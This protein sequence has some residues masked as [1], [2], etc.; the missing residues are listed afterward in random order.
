MKKLTSNTITPNKAFL[1][2]LAFF[3][4]GVFIFLFALDLMGESFK[5]TGG[6]AIEGIINAASNPFIGL[7]IGLLSTAL[8]QSSSTTTAMIVTAVASSSIDLNTAVPMIMGANVGTTITSTIISL[9][10]ISNRDEFGRAISTAVVH[11]FFNIITVLI[12]F[13]LE[14][15]YSLLTNGAEQ[16]SSFFVDKTAL[17]GAL[18][19]KT[20]FFSLSAITEAYLK[21]MSNNLVNLIISFL[22]LF[23]SIK[24]ISKAIYRSLMG[25]SESKLKKYIFNDTL[26]SFS[27]GV[28]VTG[29]IQSSSITTSIIVPFV[30][31]DKIKLEKVVPF[32]IGANIG[33][34]ITAF[35]AVMFESYA[36]VN[37]AITHLLFNIFGVVIF[38]LF[39]AL[40]NMLV[41]ISISFGNL[42]TKHRVGLVIYVLLIF[43][44][45]PFL[46]IYFNK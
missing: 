13:P 19:K 32:I 26:K 28:L 14:Y 33:T 43:F 25:T 1:S 42:V 40:R 30:A 8:I 24:F 41:K 45:I 44:L 21:V 29:A 27:W 18:D 5:I 23:L 6:G 4:F 22:M 11:D 46:L 35:I 34:T 37:I 38:L 31:T 7:F 36:V 20:F 10:Y 17:D 9:S 3:T 16:L 12:L 2:R 15:K 39:P